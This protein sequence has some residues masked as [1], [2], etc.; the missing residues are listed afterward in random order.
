MK[1]G[2]GLAHALVYDSDVSDNA[3]GALKEVHEDLAAVRQG[4]GLLHALVYGDTDAQH[5]MGN[6][7][8]MSDDMR[9]IVANMKAGKGTLGALLVDP[10]IYEDIRS[11]VGNVDRNQ[12]LRALRAL[13]DQGRREERAEGGDSVNRG[14]EEVALRGRQ[15][16]SR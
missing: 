8:A 10:S 11:L 9:E 12:V 7:N 16:A 2:P 1:R 3:A 6:V 14:S 13:L 4:N 5:L 15:G